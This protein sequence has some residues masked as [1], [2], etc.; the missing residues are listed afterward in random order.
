VGRKGS[1]ILVHQCL[2]NNPDQ[3]PSAE[4]LLQQLEATRVRIE[5]SYGSYHF[6]V[7]S[8]MMSVEER[9]MKE[10][11]C[12]IEPLFGINKLVLVQLYVYCTMMT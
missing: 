7:Q 5:R 6:K 11:D 3:R 10:K 12:E 4:E 8:A 2:H 1:S 9:Q